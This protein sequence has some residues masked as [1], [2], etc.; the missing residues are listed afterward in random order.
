MVYNC[1][2]DSEDLLHQRSGPPGVRIESWAAALPAKATRVAE[3]AAEENFMTVGGRA[4]RV[5]G[6]E[7]EEA[8]RA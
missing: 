7:R 2:S 5:A 4:G 6:W 3:R 8:L 1:A